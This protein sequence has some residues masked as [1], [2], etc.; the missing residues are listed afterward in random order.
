LMMLTALGSMSVSAQRLCEAIV[1]NALA[2]T[3]INCGGVSDNTACY[4]YD[5]LI[6]TFYE[7]SETNVWTQGSL[8]GVPQ[9]QVIEGSAVDTEADE[10]GIGYFQIAVEDTSV[11][12]NE[13]IRVMAFG[14]VILENVAS[15]DDDSGFPATSGLADEALLETF[16]FTTGG[17][18]ECQEAMNMVLVQTPQNTE[19]TLIIN[20]VPMTF[21]STIAL[22]QTTGTV[23]NPMFVTVLDGQ[24]VLYPD[25]EQEVTINEGEVSIA[26]LSSDT[27]VNSTPMLQ[28]ETGLPITDS[29]GQPVLRHVPVTVFTDPLPLTTEGEGIWNLN[30]YQTLGQIP[31]A[32]LNYP[33]DVSLPPPTVTRLYCTYGFNTYNETWEVRNLPADVTE[34]VFFGD[35]E[36]AMQPQST[37][38]ILQNRPT[39]TAYAMTPAGRLDVNVRYQSACPPPPT[40]SPIATATPVSTPTVV[41]Q[42]TA[43][44]TEE[45]TQDSFSLTATKIIADLTA[46]AQPTGD[47]FE[48]TATAL[49]ADLTVSASAA[50]PFTANIISCEFAGVISDPPARQFEV[51]F[52]FANIPAN[53]NYIE[54]TDSGPDDGFEIASP[55]TPVTLLLLDP[56][57][58]PLLTADAYDVSQVALGSAQITSSVECPPSPS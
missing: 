48:L 19:I 34:I 58:F 14:D 36:N 49:I 53:T 54:I 41:S 40:P 38:T 37:I 31:T 13:A 21:S 46:T 7:T 57:D 51:T 26:V 43:D 47:P 4:G 10:W 8:A 45:A 15:G 30:Y 11:P 3:E 39:Q 35:F 44:T 29:E 12:V 1:Q 32:L 18:S 20:D 6:S 33:I 56:S 22:G 2:M 25:S 50:L 52:D 17:D 16:Y 28:A 5:S 42:P 24:A 23:D 55:T 9:I 27:D